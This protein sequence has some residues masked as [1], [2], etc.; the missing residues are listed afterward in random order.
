MKKEYVAPLAEVIDFRIED[1]IMDDLPL[2]GP[3]TGGSG[4]GDYEGDLH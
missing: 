3:T 2:D 4:V 1:T